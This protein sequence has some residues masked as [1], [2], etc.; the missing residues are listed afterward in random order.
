[1]IARRGRLPPADALA[2]LERVAPTL[3]HAHG[4]GLVHGDLKPSNIFLEQGGHV[5]LADFGA[6]K[7]TMGAAA[8]TDVSLAARPM[9]LAPEQVVTREVNASSDVFSLACVAFECLTGAPPYHLDDVARFA[10][11]RAPVA[12]PSAAVRAPGLPPAVDAVFE[13]ALAADPDDRPAS[14]TDFVGA[15]RDAVEGGAVPEPALLPIRPPAE[16]PVQPRERGTRS[17]L[18]VAAAVVALAALIAGVAFFAAGSGDKTATTPPTLTLD[19]TRLL[20]SA[21]LNSTEAGFVDSSGRSALNASVRGVPG[22]LE[23][24][25]KRGGD[26]GRDL[27]VNPGV[28]DYLLGLDVAVVPGAQVKFDVGLRWAPGAKV[29]DLLRIDA[30]EG[31]A[32]FARFEQGATAAQSRIIAVGDQVKLPGLT[33]G[34]VQHLAIVVR[35]TTMQLYRDS[36]R[37]M[38]STDPRIP[39]AP[40]APG[41]DV[42]GVPG[43]GTVR[44]LGV[45][46]RS[47]P[48]SLPR[49]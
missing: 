17:A 7:A 13:H 40:T 47:L 39:T 48:P 36:V 8:N 22:A 29:G 43:G 16:R 28:V 42:L 24:S 11:A 2:I 19:G 20:F 46:V 21:A 12:V 26:A 6:S 25:V 18:L 35:G 15:L 41:M 23:L 37:L 49:G 34:G 32:T 30:V 14:A 44:V 10:A 45:Q 4:L 3:D 27:A 31:N 33:T 9:Y 1:M 38:S 5:S